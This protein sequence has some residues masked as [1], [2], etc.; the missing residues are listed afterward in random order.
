MYLPA[1]SCFCPGLHIL[2]FQAAKYTIYRFSKQGPVIIWWV[3]LLKRTEQNVTWIQFFLDFAPFEFLFVS[4]QNTIKWLVGTAP[5]LHVAM[6]LIVLCCNVLSLS[7]LI[8]RFFAKTF[9]SIEGLYVVGR[10]LQWPAD[11]LQTNVLKSFLRIGKSLFSDYW[12][13]LHNRKGWIRSLMNF[14]ST[15]HYV[16]NTSLFRQLVHLTSLCRRSER[17]RSNISSTAFGYIAF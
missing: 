1:F 9:G 7:R 2:S 11:V 8:F 17:K 5:S 16:R 6:L 10:W 13:Q 15:F 4:I 14:S 12:S 3:L